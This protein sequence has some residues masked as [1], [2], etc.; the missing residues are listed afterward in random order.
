MPIKYKQHYGIRY[1]GVVEK[2]NN[3]EFVFYGFDLYYQITGCG[4][5]LDSFLLFCN[6]N[7]FHIDWYN[8]QR[9]SYEKGGWNSEI[10]KRK[11]KH[12]I[13][14][15]MGKEYWEILNYRF[16]QYDWSLLEDGSDIKETY[17]CL[18]EI[19]N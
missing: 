7:N 8:F 14:D 4:L 9:T 12:N 18:F 1:T 6:T 2:E 11:L 16:S 3:I 17:R 19:N 15:I 13:I 5:D 10:L